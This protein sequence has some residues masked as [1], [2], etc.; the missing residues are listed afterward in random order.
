M[1]RW[2]LTLVVLALAAVTI[3][4]TGA[5]AGHA[6]GL[7]CAAAGCVVMGILWHAIGVH[8]KKAFERSLNLW[9]QT[10]SQQYRL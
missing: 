3:A 10:P 9:S 5:G 7:R 2:S 1:S 8:R 6:L 4:A